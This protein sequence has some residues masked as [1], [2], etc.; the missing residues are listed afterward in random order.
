DR[1][2]A[3]R[4]DHLDA[5]GRQRERHGAAE[6]GNVVLLLLHVRV[7]AAL[8][9]AVRVRDVV[10]EAG[11][12][13]GHLAHSC[14]GSFL[15]IYRGAIAPPKVTCRHAMSRIPD[16]PRRRTKKAAFL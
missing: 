10:S 4:V 5:L 13:S 14:H 16:G 8:R 7:E 12:G 9:P 1:L 15:F 11:N 6:R 2:D 3:T